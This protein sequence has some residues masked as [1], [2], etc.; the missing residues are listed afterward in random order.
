MEKKELSME[1]RL[2]IA[3]VLMGL[4]IVWQYSMRPLPT[5]PPPTKA[6]SSKRDQTKQDQAKQTASSAIPAPASKT[7]A[8]QVEVPGQVQAGSEEVFAVETEVFRVRFSNRGG[9]VRSW[10]LK[11]YKDHQA[12]PQPLELVNQKALEKVP[13]P[14]AL[15]FK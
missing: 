15:S 4:V 9:V 3:F 1:V 6:D 12:Q 14:F 10:V 5:T 8:K 2:L 13:P 11:D 7:P